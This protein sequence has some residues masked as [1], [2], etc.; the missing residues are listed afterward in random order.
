MKLIISIILLY[1]INS[2]SVELEFKGVK[3]NSA[4]NRKIC[5]AEPVKLKEATACFAD[6]SIANVPA[7][8]MYYIVDKKIMM[9]SLSY[10][11]T[12]NNNISIEKA[13]I[14]KYGMATEVGNKLKP[15]MIWKLQD[16]MI[17]F[18][19]HFANIGEGAVIFSSENV[20]QHADKVLKK[21]EAS[22]NKDL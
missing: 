13:L 10:K 22:A 16:G 11:E 15:N 14:G 18:D 1:S 6:T 21:E 17:T 7:Q 3:L 12:K 2:Y 4:F 8:A 5:K 20:L 19:K 9:I